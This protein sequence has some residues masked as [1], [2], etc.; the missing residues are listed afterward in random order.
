M[1]INPFKDRRWC[2]R[3]WFSVRRVVLNPT[4]TASGSGTCL[5]KYWC[6]KGR[7]TTVNVERLIFIVPFD[8]LSSTFPLMFTFVRQVWGLTRPPASLS[9]FT[10]E[11]Q[12]PNVSTPS[13]GRTGIPPRRGLK[14]IVMSFWRRGWGQYSV[15][16][17]SSET[18]RPQIS[19]LITFR[20]S[21]DLP[22]S[23][24]CSFPRNPCPT[25]CHWAGLGNQN[26][27]SP[28]SG[29]QQEIGH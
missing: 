8:L 7:K 28:D 26:L 6:P 20:P 14:T 23:L 11:L 21:S 5:L 1:R 4:W 12:G 10:E 27:E 16:N 18:T 15:E 13:A 29:N 25:C 2:K 9:T 24:H 19:Y 3:A 17:E 22:Q